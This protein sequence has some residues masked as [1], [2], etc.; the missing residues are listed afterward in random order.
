MQGTNNQG[1]SESILGTNSVRANS[2]N[3]VFAGTTVNPFSSLSTIDE[4]V[5]EKFEWR[6]KQKG[7]NSHMYIQSDEEEHF[8]TEPPFYNQD[9]EDPIADDPKG[10]NN[11]EESEDEDDDDDNDTHSSASSYPDG[12]ETDLDKNEFMA[13]IIP[14]EEPA[15]TSL[16]ND[17]EETTRAESLWSNCS[18]DNSGVHYLSEGIPTNPATDELGELDNEE[19]HEEVLMPANKGAPTPLTIPNPDCEGN[20]IVGASSAKSWIS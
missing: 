15:S 3:L 14:P 4:S 5:H 2:S 7:V 13:P 12:K 17:K 11:E 16:V 1:N 19:E 6:P 18:D 8:D 10:Y 9:M 20:T